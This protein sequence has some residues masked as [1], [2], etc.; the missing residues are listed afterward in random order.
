VSRLSTPDPGMKKKHASVLRFASE[1]RRLA[2]HLRRR[3]AGISESTRV[4][5]RLSI[6][7]DPPTTLTGWGLLSLQAFTPSS[8]FGIFN[9]MIFRMLRDG[10]VKFMAVFIPLMLA[11]STAMN[12]LHPGL[13]YAWRRTSVDSLL[14]MT[15]VGE[16][17]SMN[18]NS[19][20]FYDDGAFGDDGQGVAILFHLLYLA[21]LI[22]SAVMMVN[23]LIA[24]MSTTYEATQLDATRE[25]R[26]MF[27]RLVLRMELLAPSCLFTRRRH[28]VP[29]TDGKVFLLYQTNV[30]D[31]PGTDIFHGM[32]EKAQHVPQTTNRYQL[33]VRMHEHLCTLEA[34][35]RDLSTAVAGIQQ[36]LG[37]SGTPSLGDVGED[38]LQHASLRSTQ[39]AQ[40]EA[41]ASGPNV[42][43]HATVEEEPR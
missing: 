26:V 31:L 22:I 39:R 15:F 40:K 17:V 13:R 42:E 10:I 24:M 11:F 27:S 41:S 35:Q 16:S 36:H 25:W 3:T 12:V 29:P 34:G 28:L 2:L 9:I 23:L 38:R 5:P 18:T 14:M 6:S 32:D 4:D 19:G 30:D 37:M 33:M 20:P 21:F 1:L 43:F 7:L 8:R